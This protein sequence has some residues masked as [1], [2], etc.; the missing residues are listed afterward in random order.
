MRIAFIVN[1][2]FAG[3]EATD[4]R[5][6]GTEEAVVH[7]AEE[8]VVLG[9]NVVV[10]RNSFKNN[11]Q[12][13]GVL[14]ARREHYLMGRH[15]FVVNVKSHD[16]L[17]GNCPMIYFTNETNAGN[18]DL[19]PYAA[20][21]WP[22]KW[23]KDNI[24]VNN[25]NVFVVP[26]GYDERKIYP[27]PKVPKQCFYASSPDRGLDV[28]LKAWPKVH[29]M[30]PDATLILTY[31]AQAL[32][33]P[34]VI[35]LGNVDEE[36]MDDIYRTSDIWCHPATSGELFCI[37]GLKAQAACCVPVINPIMALKETVKCG[38]FN[39]SPS[40]KEGDYAD[41]LDFALTAADQRDDMRKIMAKYKWPTYADSAKKLMDVIQGVIQSK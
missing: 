2:V 5:L 31:G 32:D 10:Y 17:P 35:K 26:H 39:T 4:T 36:T 28:L 9:H 27:G 22:S 3:W 41:L 21:V 20:V 25:E 14:Y 23:A 40:G 7:W 37:T 18:F 16:I 24:P 19:S 15:D 34:G 6:G 8:F 30:H 1:P 38:F 12:H 13:N 11:M 33:V 29:K